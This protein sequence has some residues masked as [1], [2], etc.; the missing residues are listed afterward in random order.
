MENTTENEILWKDKKRILG[1]PISFT[2]YS[3]SKD[4]IFINTGLFNLNEEEILLY[5]V[6]DVSLK[7]SFWQRIFKVGSVIVKSSDQSTPV[8]EI[9]NVKKPKEVKELIYK[10]SEEMK[11]ARRIRV[12]EIIDVA[13]EDF[14]LE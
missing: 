6:L 7:L 5:R 13:D 14:G 12:G 4:R 9:R 11:M 10:Y 2:K 1:M 3:L 8:L